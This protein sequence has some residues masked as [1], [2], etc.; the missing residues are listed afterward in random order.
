MKHLKKATILI[1]LTMLLLVQIVPSAGALS[2]NDVRIAISNESEAANVI[3]DMDTNGLV[4]AS[5]VTSSY[6]AYRLGA[7]DFAALAKQKKL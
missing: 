7:H 1:F 6:K 2:Y 5:D 4:S 3:A